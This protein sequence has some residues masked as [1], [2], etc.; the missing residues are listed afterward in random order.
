MPGGPRWRGRGLAYRRQVILVLIVV[1][2]LP[3]A[4]FGI[5]AL[6]A[7]EGVVS[8]EALAQ[9]HTAVRGVAA[10]L[11]RDAADLAETVD[12]YAKWP[13]LQDEVAR[14]ALDEVRKD[15]IEFQVDQGE[16]DAISLIVGD[17]QV[18][19]GPTA[20]ATALA[21][22]ARRVLARS[23]GPPAAPPTPTSATVFTWSTSSRSTWATGPARA[24]MPRRAAR[25]GWPSPDGSTRRSWST[26]AV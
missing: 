7:V 12:S 18:V 26:P 25:S 4:V 11:A 14:L 9:T 15:V 21:T 23:D 2:I 3:L 16:I 8:E 22:L 17:Q 19:G 5:A 10:V 13:F 20:Q 6:P 24:S 1:A